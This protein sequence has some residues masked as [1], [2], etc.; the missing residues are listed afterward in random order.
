[1][2]WPENEGEV[3]ERKGVLHGP[4]TSSAS[5]AFIELQK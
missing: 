1:M 3:V 5:K 4:T 2:Q